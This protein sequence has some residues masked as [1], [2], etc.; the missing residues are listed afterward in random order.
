MVVLRRIGMKTPLA[1]QVAATREQR[2]HR[3]KLA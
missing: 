1:L 3:K 2:G